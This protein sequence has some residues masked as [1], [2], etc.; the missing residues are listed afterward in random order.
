MKFCYPHG[1]KLQGVLAMTLRSRLISLFRSSALLALLIVAVSAQSPAQWGGELRFCLRTDPKTFHPVLV[2]DPA[3]ETIRYLTGGVLIRLNR[4]TQELEPE[5]AESWKVS[6]GGRRIQFRLREGIRFSDGTS[7]S[8]ADVS[9]TVRAL[10]D[11]NVRSPTADSLRTASITAE[12]QIQ[13]LNPIEV[14]ITFPAAVAGI[15]RHFDQVA[16]VSASSP[17]KELAVLGPFVLAEHKPGSHVLL[18]RNPHYWKLDASGRRLPYLDTI[19][20]DIVQNPQAELLRFSRGQIDLITNVSPEHYKQIAGAKPQ[21]AH[22]A[23]PSLDNEILWFNQVSH[24]PLPAHKK[25]WFRSR[26]FRRAISSAINRED[27]CRLVYLGFAEPAA[28]IFAPANRF[29][30]NQNLRPHAFDSKGAVEQLHRAGFRLAKGVLRDA[31]GHPVEFSVITNAETKTRERMAALIQSD[32]KKIGIQLNVVTLD[33]PSLIER[34]SK[35]F[36]YEACLLGLTNLDLD[37]NGQMNVWLSS[38]SLHQWNPS[39]KAPATPWEAEIDKLMLA[40][41]STPDAAKRKAAFDRVQEIVWEQAP[42]IYLVNKNAL[43]LASE[44][45]RHF[46]AVALRPQTYWNIERLSLDNKLAEQR[47]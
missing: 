38:S 20:M 30:F 28:G 2:N 7:F 21:M 40:Q 29:W 15:E 16:I 24:A 17:K 31:K 4:L 5:L 11:P 13:V 36:N 10:L 9:H 41:A 44:K 8:A 45:L 34:I 23:G 37:P 39:Q 27:L 26:E 25:E 3:A 33:F 12:V 1:P 18:R 22:D 42:F 43:S 35:T 47:R 32:L 14:V 19:R 6:Q 46:K